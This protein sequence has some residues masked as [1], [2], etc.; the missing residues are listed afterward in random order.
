MSDSAAFTFLPYLRRGAAALIDSLNAP[1]DPRVVLNA[2]LEIA[3]EGGATVSQRL[4]LYGSGEI[5]G[6][7]ARAIT[8]TWP[9]RDVKD[10]ETNSFAHIEFDQADLP[11]RFTPWQAFAGAGGGGTFSGGTSDGPFPPGPTRTNNGTD[12]I[13]RLRPW[14]VLIV[15][16][17]EQILEYRAAVSKPASPGGSSPPL[18]II[19]TQLRFLPDLTQSW[20]WSHVQVSGRSSITNAEAQALFESAPHLMV[21]RIICPLRLEPRVDYRAFLVPAF[22]R[23]RVAGLGG[24][25]GLRRD[26]GVLRPAIAAGVP[27]WISDQKNPELVVELPV[28]YEWAFQTAANVDFESLVKSLTATPLPPDVGWRL[29]DASAPDV[30]LPPVAAA[31]LAI[32][33]ALRSI[34]PLPE[35]DVTDRGSFVAPFE[36]QLNL[37][38]NL[39]E[40]IEVAA[41][42]PPSYGRWLAADDAVDST[43]DGWFDAVNLDPRNRVAAGAGSAVVE[44]HDEKLLVASWRQIE[45]LPEI[46]DKLRF[47]QLARE[48][49]RRMRER[50]LDGAGDDEF[51]FLTA[52]LFQRVRDGSVTIAKRIA[53]SRIGRGPFEPAFRKLLR[54]RRR[55]LNA[56]EP[57]LLRRMNSGEIAAASTPATPVVITTT[58]QTFASFVSAAPPR[59]AFVLAR[60]VG[61]DHPPPAAPAPPTSVGDSGDASRFRAAMI[62]TLNDI[63]APRILS[64]I[65]GPL[66]L[67]DVRTRLSNAADPSSAML[68]DF[69]SRLHFAPGFVR[70]ATD[71]LEPILAAPYFDQPMYEPLRQLS[72]EWILP[73]LS[74]LKSNT[75]TL[76]EVNQPFVEAYLVGLSH[77]LGRALLWRDYP[78]DQRGTFFRQ[79]WDMRGYAGPHTR[80]ELRD[81]HPI[82]AWPSANEFGANSSR[83]PLPG[84]EPPLVL[85]LRGDLLRQY[86][87]AIVYAS[88]ALNSGTVRDPVDPPDE[89]HPIFRGTLGGDVAFF[90]FEL[91]ADEARGADDGSDDGWFFV[92]QE[93]PNEPRFGF[94]S[95]SP[96]PSAATSWDALR[97][98]H[99]TPLPIIGCIDLA[100]TSKPNTGGI[101]AIPNKP[102]A[103]HP[104]DGSTS[105]QIA[106]LTLRNPVRVAIHATDMLPKD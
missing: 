67:E 79:F 5:T 71:P 96:S 39:L 80:E 9:G 1:V 76:A 32:G 97:W 38:K 15:L 94:E 81:I 33:G 58:D 35:W 27:A 46:N 68:D 8:R 2:T 17:P 48:V 22:E 78:T 60:E 55:A 92:L 93:Q 106:W 44:R 37:P 100:D 52:P 41:V 89:R 62:A 85:V 28:Y 31:P 61:P 56:G 6:F 63:H 64:P 3:Q 53:G 29:I 88:R 26:Q 70:A 4:E 90:G 42:A 36:M 16:R 49:A 98:E 24:D 13:N 66:V 20:A 14:C 23:G 43:S 45:G 69:Q 51:F 84:G 102:I 47:A 75:I 72:E 34:E 74:A 25:P 19:K 99:V 54:R 86:P 82:D 101:A 40:G 11:W 104:S 59:P 50:R 77:E 95:G 83:P 12:G 65:P 10:A 21:S 30:S 7:D 91:T 73:G 87:T 18:S 103:W 57:S 105:A